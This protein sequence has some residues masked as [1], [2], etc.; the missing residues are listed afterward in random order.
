MLFYQMI[1][2]P[3]KPMESSESALSVSLEPKVLS[4]SLEARE[5]LILSEGLFVEPDEGLLRS[6]L[7]RDASWDFSIVINLCA[8]ILSW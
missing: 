6:S 3:Q 8:M 2:K 4:Q 5:Y 1:T 7:V